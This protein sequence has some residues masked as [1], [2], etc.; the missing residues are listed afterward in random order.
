MGGCGVCLRPVGDH[1]VGRYGSCKGFRSR[2]ED[3]D[4][5]EGSHFVALGMRSRVNSMKCKSDGIG[6][7]DLSSG[8]CL[9]V[10]KREVFQKA[11]ESHVESMWLR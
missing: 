10:G 5:A 8:M 3:E 4:T 11:E 9:Q 1:R 6:F 2:K 7:Q